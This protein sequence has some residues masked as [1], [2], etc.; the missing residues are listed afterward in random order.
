MD[1]YFYLRPRVGA[2]SLWPRGNDVESQ[3]FTT[4]LRSELT[5]YPLVSNFF[6]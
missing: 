4:L 3:I 1:G 6:E 5:T 2:V